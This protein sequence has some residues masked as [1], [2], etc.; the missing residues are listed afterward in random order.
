MKLDKQLIFIS[1]IFT[2]I[3]ILQIR[4]L[5]QVIYDLSKVKQLVCGRPEIPSQDF[6]QVLC[7][8]YY[9]TLEYLSF[10]CFERV[11]ILIYFFNS[12]ICFL[13]IVIISEVP[14]KPCPSH[15]YVYH[16]KA[17]LYNG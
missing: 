7:S 11:K 9:I 4:K 2:I 10:R 14:L 1:I 5:A 3:L 6:S 17:I 12:K 8:F 13:N 15:D 16:G